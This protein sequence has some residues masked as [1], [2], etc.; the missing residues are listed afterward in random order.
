MAERGLTILTPEHVPIR[1]IPAGLGSRFIALTVDFILIMGIVIAIAMVSQLLA[2]LGLQATV[3]ITLTFIVM[4]AYHMYFELRHQ[5][6]SPGKRFAGL[7]VIDNRGL[8]MTPQQVFVRNVVRAFDA[9][10]LFYGLG[11]LIAVFD[12]YHRRLGD[13]AA[14]T[15]VIREM[16]PVEY[17]GQLAQVRKFNSLRTPRVLRLVRHR[18]SL[19]EREYL[20]ALCLRAQKLESQLRFDLME[21]VGAHYRQKLEIDDPHLSGEN[22]V[23]DLTAL[24]FERTGLESPAS[25]REPARVG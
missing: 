12:P 23:L 19:E 21:E 16:Q 11:G 14:G 9:I 13:I 10:P 17:A 20:L 25:E 15:L 8:P 5:G 22:L 4:W 24:L 3:Q 18:I 6:R 2:L 7:R 1:L